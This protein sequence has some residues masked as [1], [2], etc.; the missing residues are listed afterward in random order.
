M[1]GVLDDFLWALRRE[2][3]AIS[4]PQAIDA[5]RAAREVGFDDRSQLREAIAC[6]VVDASERR[7]RFDHVFDDFF[8]LQSTRPVE[9]VKRLLSKKF[10]RPELAALQKL[11]R[12][13][14]PQK[15]KR[16]RTL[17]NG[18]S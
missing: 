7:P 18:G 10:T 3:F 16:L 9:L 12:E 17:L 11:L 6:V 14:M 13:F 1:L 4:T 5:A 15:K 8:S 2:G